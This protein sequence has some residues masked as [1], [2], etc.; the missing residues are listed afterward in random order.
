MRWKQEK[1]RESDSPISYIVQHCALE[2]NCVRQEEDKYKK[3]KGN[4]K[5]ERGGD[6]KRGSGIA[7]HCF[8][9]LHLRIRGAKMV[10]MKQ[11]DDV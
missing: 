4:G 1:K 5:R 8:P 7:L 11:V 10:I 3:L 6:W 9:L 2:L